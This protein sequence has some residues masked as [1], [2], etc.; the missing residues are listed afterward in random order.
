[1][2]IESS[3]YKVSMFKHPRNKIRFPVKILIVSDNLK[4]HRFHRRNRR[5]SEL[6]FGS[7][8]NRHDWSRVQNIK[9]IK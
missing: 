8:L 9:L 6:I 1:M 2:F 7:V 5:H 3:N 4:Y